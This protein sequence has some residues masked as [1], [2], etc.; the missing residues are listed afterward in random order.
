MILRFATQ[1]DEPSVVS[2]MHEAGECA[3]GF[4]YQNLDGWCLVAEDHARLLGYTW[5]DL[6]RPES[7][8]RSWA[9][10]ADGMQRARVADRLLRTT[11]QLVAG[12]GSQGL[13]GFA[14][15]DERQAL[16][17]HGGATAEPGWRIRWNLTPY[18]R[19]QVAPAS[20]G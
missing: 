10:Q 3:T 16:Y 1:A 12:Y 19:P 5:F 6:G 18:V 9:V 2:L 8:L 11:R 17:Q 4:Q 14:R 20:R 7:C 13:W 15:T